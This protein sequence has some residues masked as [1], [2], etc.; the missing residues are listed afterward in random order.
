MIDDEWRPEAPLGGAGSDFA[1]EKDGEVVCPLPF[2]VRG[3]HS[4]HRQLLKDN[5]QPP[6]CFRPPGARV[7]RI[8]SPL[9]FCSV[10]AL[11]NGS[12]SKA[13]HQDAHRVMLGRGRSPAQHLG[14][15]VAV[16]CNVYC[17]GVPS[18]ASMARG[19]DRSIINVGA[20]SS[21]GISPSSVLNRRTRST[22]LKPTAWR[23]S[24]NILVVL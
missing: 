22:V 15:G 5:R 18:S 10:C 12:D 7:R 17:C 1:S 13:S 23:W 24:L 21:L 6:V 16:S 20:C 3:T 4:V 14:V 8:S 19:L 2:A 11:E 9:R